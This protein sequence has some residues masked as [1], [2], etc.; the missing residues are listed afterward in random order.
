MMYYDKNGKLAGQTKDGRI[1]SESEMKDGLKKQAD[2][3][4]AKCLFP[5]NN[6]LPVEEF[7]QDDE[8]WQRLKYR[9]Y[10]RLNMSR[11][12]PVND[13]FHA[14][15]NSKSKPLSRRARRRLKKF[16]KY[17]REEEIPRMVDTFLPPMLPERI[18]AMSSKDLSDRPIVVPI[19]Y[20][21]DWEPK[22]IEDPHEDMLSRSYQWAITDRWPRCLEPADMLDNLV[23]HKR[24]DIFYLLNNFTQDE[25]LE[26]S[27]YDDRIPIAVV[28]P[29]IKLEGLK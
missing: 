29:E 1:L 16:D 12:N 22:T 4:W 28:L 21:D 25:L 17:M 15:L 23:V 7:D 18:K 2:A 26:L 20:D 27:Q 24:F 6:G 13:N 10:S 8:A 9:R 3:T 14:Y 11:P 5:H 19:I